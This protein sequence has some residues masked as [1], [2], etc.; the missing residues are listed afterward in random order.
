MINKNLDHEIILHFD[1]EDKP[2][3]T[4]PANIIFNFVTHSAYHRGQLAIYLR[5][6]G[7][8]EIHQ[9]DFNPYIYTL[10]QYKED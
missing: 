9:T 4:S 3:S 7:I 8:P 6:H 5:L 10:G 1:R 2:V